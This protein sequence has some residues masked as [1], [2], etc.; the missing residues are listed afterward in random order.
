M[1]NCNFNERIREMPTETKD[2]E[3]RRTTQDSQYT[4]QMEN[5]QNKCQMHK[6]NK[7]NSSE[8]NAFYVFFIW[9]LFLWLD[10]K[11]WEPDRA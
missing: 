10:K 3:F 1:E 5:N 6:K 4:T 8:V 7:C 11:D 9:P 2:P